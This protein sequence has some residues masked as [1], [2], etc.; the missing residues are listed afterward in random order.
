MQNWEEERS[1]KV[2]RS[3][4]LLPHLQSGCLRVCEGGNSHSFTGAAEAASSDLVTVT[5][6]GHGSERLRIAEV[7]LRIG[8]GSRQV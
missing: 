4:E 3:R 8:C 6:E 7:L 2:V 1:E 5:G